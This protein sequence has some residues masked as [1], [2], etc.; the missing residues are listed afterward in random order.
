[1]PFAWHEKPW[2]KVPGRGTGK[3]KG[4]GLTAQFQRRAVIF[5]NSTGAVR[6][7]MRVPAQDNLWK[8]G[9]CPVRPED[10]WMAVPQMED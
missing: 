10:A 5:R 6:P 9:G 1:M 4:A 8:Y 7:K 3:V 2:K